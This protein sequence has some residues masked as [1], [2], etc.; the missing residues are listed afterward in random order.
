MNKKWSVLAST[1]RN[2][3]F[4]IG[5]FSVCA[6]QLSRCILFASPD[7]C[8]I[9]LHNDLLR[10][11]TCSVTGEHDVLGA[12]TEKILKLYFNLKHS[13]AYFKMPKFCSARSS[14][15]TR[16]SLPLQKSLKNSDLI[17]AT[18]SRL[19]INPRS[20]QWLQAKSNNHYLMR[21]QS[22]REN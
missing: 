5:I 8:D 4:R 20:S 19:S 2:S 14:Y 18:A 12:Q 16:R 1:N 15:L 3:V 11:G 13:P 10:N 6:P 21:T 7:A 17:S 9:F 22:V